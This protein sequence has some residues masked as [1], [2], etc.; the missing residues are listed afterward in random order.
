MTTV[1]KDI[2]IPPDRKITLE[3][4]ADCPA[5]QATITVI[6]EPPPAC[7]KSGGKNGIA[8]LRGKGKGKVWMADDFDAPLEDFA[9]YM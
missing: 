4:P 8:G 5:G 7:V 9:E 2:V 1:T 6:V 3:L